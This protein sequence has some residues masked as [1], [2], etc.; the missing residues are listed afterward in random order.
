[1]AKE[2]VKALRAR[3]KA[4]GRRVDELLQ[5]YAME[6]FLYRL[7]ASPE[8]AHFIL[9]GALLLRVWQAP[10]L[11]PT[12]DI[13]LLG[14]LSNDLNTLQKSLERICHWP[15]ADDGVIFDAGDMKLETIIEDADYPGVRARFLAHIG[16]ARQMMRLDI[17]FG[18]A[19]LVQDQLRYPTL[20]EHPTPVLWGYARESSIAEKYQALVKLGL[21]NS[22]MK[23]YYDIWLLS[24]RFLFEGAQLQ[25]AIVQTF[26][27]RST[28]LEAYPVGLSAAFVEDATKVAQWQG[29]VRRIQLE[30]A[31]EL[32]EAVMAAA[33][34]LLPPT[35]AAM[36]GE[37]L[38]QI[39]LPPGPWRERPE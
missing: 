5:Y 27:Q 28:P 15:V 3:A 23:D 39:W 12:V 20:L 1:V 8:R 32:A 36:V 19:A 25:Q 18:D 21:V 16:H 26:K 22:R 10:G 9:K 38:E 24:R 29:F 31:P 14:K 33:E 6:R 2:V 17:G 30:Q 13:D 11:R 7:S 34:L 4:E 37:P 35:K